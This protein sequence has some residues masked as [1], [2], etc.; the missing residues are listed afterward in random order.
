MDVDRLKNTAQ[1]AVSHVT[2]GPEAAPDRRGDSDHTDYQNQL[3]DS[4][5]TDYQN[6]PGDSDQTD[7]QNQLDGADQRGRADRRQ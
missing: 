5:Q 3:D 1:D 2:D 4:D 7:Y 6:Q